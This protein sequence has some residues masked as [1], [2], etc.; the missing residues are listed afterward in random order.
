MAKNGG[1]RLLQNRLDTNPALGSRKLKLGTFQTNLDSGCVMSG[2]DGR[3]DITWPNTVALAKLA[4]EMEFE[5]I[6]PVARWRGFGGANN[7][8]GPGFETYT[9]AA[10]IAA[11]TAKSGVISTSHISLVHPL[12]A[13][14]QCTVIDH[15]SNGRFMLN[16]V[17]GWNGPEMDMLGVPLMRHEDRYACA[18]E[19]LGIIR[20]LWTEDEEFD[21]EGRFYQVK[22]GYLQPKP[23]QKPCPPVM[24][25]GASERGRHFAAKNCDLAFTLLRTHDFD[26][27]A[28]H[29]AD[30]QR[31]AREE[32][33]RTIRVWT[34]AT[35]VHGE[36]EQEAR[37]FYDYSV[38]EKGDWAAAAN[39]IDSMA[40]EI[41][42][43]AY[44]P[45]RRRAM[46]E[47][48]ISGWGGHPLVGTKEQIVDKLA[49]LS[50]MGMD[51]VL[52]SFPRFE[53]GMREFRDVILPL[54]KQAGLRDAIG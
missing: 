34:H 4:D 35:V 54:V 30:Y 10:G 23:I 28:A 51:G 24:N 19:W 26:V 7:P 32:Y 43:R 20:R 8:Q 47:M 46:A 22:K 3:L 12:I 21:H 6:V 50:R 41:N 29:V 14:K 33:G 36:T 48:F 49:T 45:E 5:A 44:P 18:E 37:S 1:D 9:W 40:A 11:S 15:I 27:N 53:A 38:H 31:L 25:A 42:E 39:V 52:L 2:L 16:I 13:A 17:C